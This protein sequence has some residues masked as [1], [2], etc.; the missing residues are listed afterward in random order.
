MQA[1][2]GLGQPISLRELLPEAEFLGAG[3]LRPSGC[4][5]DSRDVKPGWLFAAL[6]G[7]RAAGQQH[8]AD[9]VV[10]G[11]A[12]VLC[13]PPVPQ[14]GVPVCVVPDARDAY[15]RICQALA[16]HPSRRL[17]LVGV[18]GTN[19]KT[20]TSWLIASVLAA[21]DCPAGVLGTLGYFDGRQT[22]DAP[23]TTPPADVLARLLGR[24]VDNGC[25]HAVME[26]SSHALD[27]RRVAGVRFDVACVTNVT[28]DHLDYHRSLGDYRLAKSRLFEH[29]APEGVAVLNAD[30]P[31]SAALV[32]RINGPA[33]TVGIRSAAEITALP[34]EQFASEQTFLLSAGSETMPVRTQMIGRHHVYNCLVAAAVGLSCG[35]ELATIVRGLEQLGHVPGRLE[36]IECGQPF[37]VFVDFAHTPDAL[38]GALRTLREVTAGRLVCVFGAGG[39][40]DRQKR[41]LMGRAVEEEADQA[42]VTSDN[43]RSED[44]QRIIGEVMDG[45]C[46]PTKAVPIADRAEAI[47]FALAAARPGDCVL[48]AGKGHETCQI[49]GLQRIPL[50]DRQVARQWLYEVRPYADLCGS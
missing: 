44:P 35:I 6:P 12:A 28:R 10:R 20:T 38:R 22:D 47:R 11:C 30:D 45:F 49:V 13:Q 48:V 50:D 1:C 36:R 19:G 4:A 3:D 15:G 21:A 25:S 17:K 27:Q 14:V 16:G 26:V 18:T 46:D 5:C 24:I 39:D 32:Q 40:R 37:G 9:A 2:P 8:A 41:P 31:V 43:P 42:V 33:L 23:W 7:A 29:L 34:V